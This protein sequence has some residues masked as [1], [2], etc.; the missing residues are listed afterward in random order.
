LEKYHK[1]VFDVL[2]RQFIGNFEEMYQAEL[3]DGFDSWHQ[4]D[5]RG[6]NRQF[7]ETLTKNYNFSSC[8]DIGCGKGALSNTLKRSN[9][10]VFAVDLSKTAIS[11]VRQRYPEIKSDVLDLADLNQYEKYIADLFSE[12]SIKYFNLT[13]ISE[14]LSYLENWRE[15]IR[16]C[17]ENSEYLLISLYIPPKA[18]GFVKTAESLED[19]VSNCCEVIELIQLKRSNFTILFVRS[20]ILSNLRGV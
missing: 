13:L 5:M 19:E 18:I 11:I 3:I 6:L 14:V 15:V 4:D 17:A 10:L 9:N 7:I 20:K 2:K 1:Y 12:F 16:R 8:L